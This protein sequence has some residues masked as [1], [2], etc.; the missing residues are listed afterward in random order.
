[1]KAIG[2]LDHRHIVRAHDA[3]EIDGTPMLVMEY[4]E[5]LDLG[6]IV[7][8]V[9]AA[10]MREACEL[11]RQAALGLQYVARARPG[12]SRH[13]AVE[14]HADPPTAR[15][16]FSTWAG[17]VPA[18]IGPPGTRRPGQPPA[19]RDDRHRPGPGHARL[20][21]P[22]AGRQQPGRR[23]SRR[24]LQPGLHAVQVA[25]GRAPFS[26]EGESTPAT[27]L[28]AH[29]NQEPRPLGQVRPDLPPVLEDIVCGCWPRIRPSVRAARRSSRRHLGRWPPV[30]SGQLL[31]RAEGRLAAGEFKTLPPC[32]PASRLPQEATSFPTVWPFVAALTLLGV[33]LVGGLATVVVK[34]VRNGRDGYPRAGRRYR[35]GRPPRPGKGPAAGPRR[36]RTQP[37]GPPRNN[38]S[39]RRT[40]SVR[41]SP[42]GGSTGA[43]R[44]ARLCPKAEGVGTN[45]RADQRAPG[46]QGG[47]IPR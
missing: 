1:M 30:Q 33:L 21:G 37:T 8:R 4:L 41:M 29:V 31:A 23:H 44:Y 15:S 34:I 24:Y 11:A 5:G 3:R 38:V 14:P 7:R 25:H 10:A 43:G 45:L 12:A 9:G 47:G 39:R 18:S 46:P 20:H 27:K 36:R 16:R 19:T 35:G 28:A 22:G 13:Q 2:K 40:T 26:G 6:E 32:H 17:P 42:Y